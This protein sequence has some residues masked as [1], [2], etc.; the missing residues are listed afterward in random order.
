MSDF[1]VTLYE[2]VIDAIYE[3]VPNHFRSSDYVWFISRDIADRIARTRGLPTLTDVRSIHV[4]ILEDESGIIKL[5]KVI[6]SVTV[7]NN[8]IDA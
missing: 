5:L 6:S 4:L 1:N 2:S 8:D 3:R 7:C